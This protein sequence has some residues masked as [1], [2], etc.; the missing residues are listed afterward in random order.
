MYPGSR[1]SLF[2]VYFRR[3][4]PGFLVQVLVGGIF[5]ICFFFLLFILTTLQKGLKRLKNKNLELQYFCSDGFS[6][7]AEPKTKNFFTKVA[8]S[9][10]G[11]VD[12]ST[13]G[14]F[15][16]FFASSQRRTTIKQVMGGWM[17]HRLDTC[18]SPSSLGLDSQLSQEF[19]SWCC[20]ILLMVLLR[21]VSRYL[22][23]SIKPI[24]Y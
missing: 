22:I 5:H 18:L 3:V 15:F 2:I 8:G 7:F 12:L 20:C 19:F 16:Y 14:G 6:F 17:A 21:T 10:D 4:H 1:S 13:G 24:G 9:H 23:M 11:S